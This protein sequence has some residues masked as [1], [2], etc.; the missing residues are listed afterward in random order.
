MGIGIGFGQWYLAQYGQFDGYPEGQG[1]TLF[2]FLSVAPNIDSLKVGLENNIYTPTDEEI[3]E[4]Y[5]EGEDSESALRQAWEIARRQPNTPFKAFQGGFHTLYPSLSRNTSAKILGIIVRTAQEDKDKKL[6]IYKE[7][8]YVTQW[9][10]EWAYVVD[11]D[12]EILE[13]YKGMHGGFVPKHD[14]HQFKDVGGENDQVP[15]L[16]RTFE[17]SELF[18]LKDDKEFVTKAK[19]NLP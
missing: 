12:K 10:C 11:L 3:E 5:R 9:D 2:R 18:L 1:V 19:E 14:G 15:G 13:I 16:V 7:V 4:F 17:F 8:E 6:P